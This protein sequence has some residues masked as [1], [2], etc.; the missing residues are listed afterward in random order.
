[1]RFSKFCSVAHQAA[2]FGIG[3]QRIHRW[4]GVARSQRGEVDAP[5]D[6]EVIRMDQECVG[7][8]LHKARK[9]VSISAPVLAVKNS[10]CGPIV[11]AAA[12]TSF[13]RD[14]VVGF[15]GL[16]NTAKRVAFGNSSCKS[17]S[18]LA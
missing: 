4:H 15:F 3:A 11:A 2:G 8:L 1:M 7:P 5:I 10:I 12:S 6:G 18:R 14:S 13:L 17:P 9:G 16:T